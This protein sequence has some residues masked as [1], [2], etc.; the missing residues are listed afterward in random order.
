MDTKTTAVWTIGQHHLCL[1]VGRYVQHLLRLL[2]APS[3][4]VYPGSLQADG[5]VTGHG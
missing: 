4:S 3:A 2:T 5:L 1:A